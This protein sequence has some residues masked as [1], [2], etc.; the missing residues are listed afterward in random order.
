MEIWSGTQFRATWHR[1]VCPNP[2]DLEPGQ[3]LPGRKSVVFFMIPNHDVVSGV[4]DPTESC[5]SPSVS[6]SRCACIAVSLSVTTRQKH[7]VVSRRREVL[8]SAHESH[9]S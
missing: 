6:Q 7:N 3:V 1:V 4:D 5:D 9:T 2:P 8:V